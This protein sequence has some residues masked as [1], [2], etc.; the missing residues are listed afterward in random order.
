[1]EV[2]PYGAPALDLLWG[3]SRINPVLCKGC[4]TCAVTCPSKA[5]RLQHFTPTQILAQVDALVG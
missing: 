2:C 5:I 4:G 1:V 3:V